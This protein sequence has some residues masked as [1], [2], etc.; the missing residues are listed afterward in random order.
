MATT[1]LQTIYIERNYMIT[2]KSARRRTVKHGG[3]QKENMPKSVQIRELLADLFEE[4]IISSANQGKT[5]FS[6]LMNIVRPSAR[7]RRL[8]RRSPGGSVNLSLNGRRENAST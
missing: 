4:Q 5:N 8:G 2:A 6:G 7:R 3:P 1:I